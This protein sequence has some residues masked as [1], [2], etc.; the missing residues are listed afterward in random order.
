MSS[1]LSR[2]ASIVTAPGYGIVGYLRVVSWVTPDSI[3]H[4]R[5]RVV[6]WSALQVEC[7]TADEV[8]AWRAALWRARAAGTLAA[9]EIV[10]GAG[11]VLLDGV[12]EPDALAES[13]RA[14][15]PPTPTPRA[16]AA[17]EAVRIP[18]VYDG[19]DLPWVAA[20]WG[21]DVDEVVRRH[22]STEYRVAF[23]G[24]APGFGYLTGLPEE[25]SVP[26]LA[27]PRTRVP[28]GSVGLAGPYTGIYPSASPGG[29]LLIGRTDL[30]LFDVHADPPALLA[31]GVTVHFD[32]A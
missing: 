27:T 12:P 32:P 26:R 21:V 15:P 9:T 7:G 11:T 8:E 4:V 30:A 20:H 23:C 1:G 14:W 16:A 2:A 28:A 3:S 18:V 22:R 6:G 29:W 24:F 5:V 17:P 25:L 10:P 19:E 31:P 13:L